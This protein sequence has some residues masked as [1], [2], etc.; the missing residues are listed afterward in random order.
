MPA[1]KQNNQT[2]GGSPAL[3]PALWNPNAACLWSL[4]L[5]P[6]FGTYIQ[7]RNWITLNKKREATISLWWFFG[8]IA[9]ITVA[10]FHSP[11]KNL[12]LPLLLTWYLAFGKKQVAHVQ[13]E[14]GGEYQRKGWLAPIAAALT[15]GIG[16]PAAIGFALGFARAMIQTAGI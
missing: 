13:A 9:F 1:A 5:T 12:S 14:L 10:V 7:T 6:I 4:V 15:I 8:W 16:V 2:G 3:A 11:V